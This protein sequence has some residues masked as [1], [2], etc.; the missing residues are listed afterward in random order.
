MTIGNPTFCLFLYLTGV[1]FWGEL[2][3][4]GD[5]SEQKIKYWPIRT[6]EIGGVRL[7]DVLY[8]RKKMLINNLLMSDV[9]W[10]RKLIHKLRIFEIVILNTKWK[11]CKSRKNLLTKNF[12]LTKIPP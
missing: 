4:V 10:K 3:H 1:H 12:T 8:A 6:R 7:K 11:D 2:Q 9:Y 5:V